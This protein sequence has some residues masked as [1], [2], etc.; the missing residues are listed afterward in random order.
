MHP[1]T[2][3]YRTDLLSHRYR[4]LNDVWYTDTAFATVKSLRG[5]TCSQIFTNT[6]MVVG[7]PM[8]SKS[9]AGTSLG[10][11]CEEVG[12]P[13][14]IIFDNAAEQCGPKTK[15]MNIIRNQDIRWR[16][17]EPY[18]PWQNRAE[19]A[20]REVKRKM[21]RRQANKQVPPRVWDYLLIYE[22]D[23]ISRT[24]RGGDDR[25]PY[26]QVT[27]ETPDISEYT[28]FDF[29]DW[30]WFWDHPDDAQ[31]P[32][33]GRWLGISHRIGSAMCFY[34]LKSNGNVVSRT[35]VQPVPN[36]DRQKDTVITK[37]NRFDNEIETMVR[38]DGYFIPG[39]HENKFFIHDEEDYDEEDTRQEPHTQDVE[40][41]HYTP[42]TMD[43]F[44]GSE[45][46]IP[47]GDGYIAA[48]VTKRAKGPDGNPIG[49][50]HTNPL[51]DTRLY[52]IEQVDGTIRELQANVI[53]ENLFSQSDSEGR[54]HMLMEEIVSHK[55]DGTAIKKGDE[56]ISLPNRQPRRKITTRGWKLQVM[57]KDGSS[58]WVPL[59]ELK[60]SY[61][62]EVAEYAV[63]AQIHHEP[64]FAS[65]IQ[66][67]LRKR[68]RIIS[69][70]KS[71]YWKTTHK[72]GIELPHSV[73]EAYEIDRKT[74]TDHWRRAIEKE[75]AKIRGMGT[76]EVWTNGSPDDLRA[77]K[78]KLPGFRELG[79]HMVFDIK[80]DGKFTRK[81]RLVANGNET[82]PTKDMTYSSVV[83]RDSVR[84]AFLYAA[85]N[86]LDVLGCDVSNAYLN[87]PCREKLWIEAGPEFGDDQ[88][89]V[90]IIQRA[91]YGLRS[92]GAAWRKMLTQ[93]MLDL[94]YTNTLADQ[95]VWRRTATTKD[96]FEYYNG[97]GEGRKSILRQC[98]NRLTRI[99]RAGM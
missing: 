53:S 51:L 61:P 54:Q 14:T 88:G 2:R 23:I 68:N 83:G 89:S 96:G 75:M 4:R 66:D 31:N 11:L 39:T 79:V 18:S 13:N 3:R 32:H 34:I 81:A 41:L 27:G 21:K 43:P 60:E 33:L 42:D 15:F 86:D 52:E 44:V 99:G 1:L 94:G 74:G 36:L 58:D 46:R 64:A 38:A 56:F 5:N 70:I 48:R 67:V 24:V 71:R 22:C 63:A 40:D 7:V 45:V 87:A 95:D 30:V 26:E 29:Y 93:V 57:W 90:I 20:I 59:S 80:M 77:G 82:A 37:M 84:I 65:W 85:L 91:L 6:R 50:S 9:E 16:S 78:V 69:K 10:T 55:K 17:T 62:M 8:E 73:E 28:D 35:S 92:S 49:K 12:V 19:D 76:F 98:R 25:T 47:Q 72:F 97:S